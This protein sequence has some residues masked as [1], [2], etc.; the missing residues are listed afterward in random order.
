MLSDGGRGGKGGPQIHTRVAS[1]HALNPPQNFYEDA[2]ETGITA[3]VVEE[4]DPEA[5]GLARKA[6]KFTM[7]AGNT[8][9]DI[10]Q[11]KLWEAVARDAYA[12]GE[13]GGSSGG[14]RRG[15]VLAGGM[16]RGSVL[17]GRPRGDGGGGGLGAAEVQAL[18]AENAELK[19]KVEVMDGKL[20]RIVAMLEGGRESGRDVG[21]AT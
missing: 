5:R 16:R 11:K 20:D 3:A 13:G 19:K 4:T 21:L 18:K 17:M 9:K 6:S 10:G 12:F 1:R 14:Q 2:E 8:E 15:S 7:E